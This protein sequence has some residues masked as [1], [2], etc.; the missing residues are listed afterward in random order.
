MRLDQIA[1][2]LEDARIEGDP[3]TE[4]SGLAYDNRKVESGWLYFCVPGS[5]T[6]GHLFAP[7]AVSAGASALVVDRPLGL[8]V[9]EVEVPDVRQA[10]APIAAEFEGDPTASLTVAGITGTNGKTTIAW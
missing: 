6:D 2:R 8:E 9:A 4:V 3:S 5:V 7:E 1:G 10:M